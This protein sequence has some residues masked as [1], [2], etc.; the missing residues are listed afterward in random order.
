MNETGSGMSQIQSFIDL[1]YKNFIEEDH[2][3]FDLWHYTDINGL[4]GVIRDE[5]D[6]YGNLHFWFTRSD[7]LNDTSEGSHIESLYAEKC[8]ELCSDGTV[9]P[10]FY[11]LIKDIEIP[12]DQVLNYPVPAQD[13]ESHVSRMASAPCHAYICSFCLKEDSLDMWRYYSDANS[14]YGLKCSKDLFR[15]Y[16]R[17]VYSDYDENAVYCPIKAYKVVYD[18]ERKAQLLREIISDAYSLFCNFDE[19]KEQMEEDIK[20][21]IQYML[22]MFRFRFKHQCYA[23]EQEYRF[24]AYVP[25]EK[26]EGLANEL[27]VVEYRAQNGILVPHIDLMVKDSDAMLE[28]ILISPFLKDKSAVSTMEDYLK[29][30]G[31]ACGVRKSELPV[32][33]E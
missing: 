3:Y 23:S 25:Y 1:Y 17:Y 21:F 10:E 11:E 28:E 30:C 7:Y 5:K 18:D 6:E 27:P 14:G 22:K 26:P 29:K 19:P 24:V 20:V 31:V 8:L 15:E 13:K 32:R 12:D 2:E 4:M 16:E 9:S 33:G